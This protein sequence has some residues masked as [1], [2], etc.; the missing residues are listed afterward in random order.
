MVKALV[1]VFGESDGTDRSI[2]NVSSTA[3]LRP[4]AYY[5]GYSVSKAAVDALTKQLA[6]ELAPMGIRVN[7]VSPGPTSTDMAAGTQQR[8]VDRLGIDLATLSERLATRVPLARP[9]TPDEQ[10][11]VIEFL[12]SP[13][14]SYITGQIIQVDGGM[15][16]A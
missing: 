4:L 11:A 9:S 3:G 7:A 1:P 14:A 5:G 16:V 15:T 13:R 6:V 8:A 2:I 12:A 10:A